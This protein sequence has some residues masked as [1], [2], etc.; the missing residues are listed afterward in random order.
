MSEIGVLRNVFG[1]ER[2]EVTGDWWRLQSEL[3]TIS[4]PYQILFGCSNQEE[5]VGH[6]L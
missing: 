1:A 4:T 5:G 6:G 3:C 2:E